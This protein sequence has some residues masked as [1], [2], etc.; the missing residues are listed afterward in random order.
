MAG[1]RT[2]V[3]RPQV[4]FLL[5]AAFVLAAESFALASR[6]MVL[7]PDAVR[8]AVIFD[9]C[10]VPA[11][12]WWGLVVRRR[13][14]R[15]RTIARVAVVS[16]AFC[17]LIFGREVRLLAL[18]LEL[19]LIWL[20]VASVRRALR[21]RSAADAATALRTGLSDALGDSAAARAAASEFAVLWYALFSWGRA[22]P[23]AS[24]RTSAPAGSRSTSPSC[25]PASPRRS[26]CTSSSAAGGRSPPRSA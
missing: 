24:R 13:L 9:L 14:A 23:R 17:A 2:A 6:G 8:A 15:P 21:A 1:M 4:V 12:L 16:V 22:G 5:L 20:A 18:P 3:A 7:H 19:A 26:P 10:V 25:S 11:L